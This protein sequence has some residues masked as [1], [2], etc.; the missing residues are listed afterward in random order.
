MHQ[1]I[2]KLL[3]KC[4][5]YF[6]QLASN[7]PLSEITLLLSLLHHCH[8]N[9]TTCPEVFLTALKIA[10]KTTFSAEGTIKVQFD[11]KIPNSLFFSTRDNTCY[12]IKFNSFELANECTPEIKN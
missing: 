1:G 5:N 8:D 6:T 3:I 7:I 10:Y 11:P 4:Y 2:I 12:I 9:N